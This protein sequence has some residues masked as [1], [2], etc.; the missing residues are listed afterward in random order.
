MA[1]RTPVNSPRYKAAVARAE[2]AMDSK[3]PG[4][5]EAIDD[6]VRGNKVR[7]IVAQPPK[8]LSGNVATSMAMPDRKKVPH[9]R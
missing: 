4:M 2:S 5:V 1:N 3:Q 9:Q 8:N 7:A 6:L